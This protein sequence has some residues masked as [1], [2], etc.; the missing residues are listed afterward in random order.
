M[1]IIPTDLDRRLG[2]Y[3]AGVVLALS[4]S[5]QETGNVHLDLLR[6]ANLAFWI[7]VYSFSYCFSLAIVI[8]GQE[9]G[10]WE[11]LSGFIGSHT[12]VHRSWLPF[13]IFLPYFFFRRGF[14]ISASQSG[15]RDL[16]FTWDSLVSYRRCLGSKRQVGKTLGIATF[17]MYVRLSAIILLIE[18]LS[19]ISSPRYH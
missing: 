11:G 14:V 16:G 19:R 7:Y 12:S 5:Y 8:N 18:A 13:S 10:I 4:E 1:N 17:V 3:F 9:L 15:T 6:R 2:L